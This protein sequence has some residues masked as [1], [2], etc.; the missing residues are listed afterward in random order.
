MGERVCAYLVL[1]KGAAEPTVASIGDFLA[2]H[3][4]MKNKLPERVILAETLP[5]SP[6]G[7]ILK[8]VLREQLAAAA[9]S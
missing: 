7:K 1:R 2:G 9:A 3:G 8:R 4:L 5:T 6:V